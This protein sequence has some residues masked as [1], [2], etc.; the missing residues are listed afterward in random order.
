MIRIECHCGGVLEVPGSYI[1]EPAQCPRCARTLRL[2]SADPAP[3][4]GFHARLIIRSGP[5]RVGEQILLGG[6]A[7][8]AVG[9]EPGCH[10]LLM[11]ILV[12]RTH[13]FLFR[14][15]AGGWQIQDNRSRNGLYVNTRRVA[16]HDLRDGDLIG[17]GEFALLFATSA[18]EAARLVG[19]AG[20]GGGR[21]GARRNEDEALIPIIDDDSPEP[22]GGE[23]RA[24]PWPSPWSSS[25][26][27]KNSPTSHLRP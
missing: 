10:V 25:R 19:A 7:T 8:V 11:G 14:T 15:H 26:S 23:G 20:A 27:W 13:A 3:D 1:G 17:V 2:A 9:K 4:G 18:P 6:R 24:A 5:E 21:P 12:S 22:A 16:H